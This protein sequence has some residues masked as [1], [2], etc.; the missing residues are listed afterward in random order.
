MAKKTDTKDTVK[1][2]GRGR[3]PK[4]PNKKIEKVLNQVENSVSKNDQLAETLSNIQLRSTSISSSSDLEVSE[5]SEK[6]LGQLTSII[7]ELDEKLETSNVE[8]NDALN[9]LKELEEIKVKLLAKKDQ[10]DEIIA[11]EQD[12]IHRADIRLENLDVNHFTA[13]RSPVVRFVL[14]KIGIEDEISLNQTIAKS[15]SV[16]SQWNNKLI[17]INSALSK[18]WI[19]HQDTE[20]MVAIIKGISESYRTVRMNLGKIRRNIRNSL[21]AQENQIEQQMIMKDYLENVKKLQNV[22]PSVKN[23]LSEHKNIVAGLLSG[24]KFS[25]PF[26]IEVEKNQSEIIEPSRNSDNSISKK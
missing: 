2:R 19:A 12:R 14:S 11:N 8:L 6:T 7:K 23:A 4:N 1:K 21:K 9:S 24:K 22:G 13:D 15:E 25:L 17:E 10:I 16:I 26:D 20:N 5:G 3:P 18:A